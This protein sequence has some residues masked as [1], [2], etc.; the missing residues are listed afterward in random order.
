VLGKSWLSGSS[1]NAFGQTVIN[2]AGPPPTAFANILKYCGAPSVALSNFPST[3]NT[4]GFPSNGTLSAAYNWALSP[5]PSYY[6]RYKIWYTGSVTGGGAGFLMSGFPAI[7]YSGGKGVTGNG[8][9]ATGVKTADLPF[10]GACDT[11][12]TQA[13]PIEMA[14]GFLISSVNS[15]LVGGVVEFTTASTLLFGLGPTTGWKVKPGNLTYNGGAFPA[16]PNIDGSWTITNTAATKFTLDGSGSLNPALISV[17]GAGGPGVQTEMLTNAPQSIQIPAGVTVT[18]L[19]DWGMVKSVDYASTGRQYASSDIVNFLTSTKPRFV[20]VMDFGA[21]QGD[22]STGYGPSGP[23]AYNTQPGHACWYL[24]GYQIKDYLT[25]SSSISNTGSS[26]SYTDVYTC[27]SPP[28]S[29]TVGAYEDGEIVFGQIGSSSANTGVRPG[30]NVNSRGIAPIFDGTAGQILG[31]FWTGSAPSAGTSFTASFSGAGLN[32]THTVNFTSGGTLRDIWVDFATACQADTTLRNLAIFVGNQQGLGNSDGGIFYCPNITFSGG[33]VVASLGGANFSV[34][35]T[36]GAGT[37]SYTF[38][39]LSIGQL[40]NSD[41][42]AFTY[43]KRF[44]G[45]LQ[46]PSAYTIGPAIGAPLEFYADMCT[47][48]NVGLY[49]CIGQLWSDARITATVDMLARAGVREL[50]LE[51]SNETWNPY[52]QEYNFSQAMG[53]TF[54]FTQN[55][56]NSASSSESW[57]GLRH[58]QAAQLAIAAWTAAGKGR[59][60]LFMN[61][62]FQLGSTSDG[63]GMPYKMNGGLLNGT[64]T[65]NTSRVAFSAYG[66]GSLSSYSVNSSAAPN[67][68]VDFS[69]AIGHAP[70]WFGTQFCLGNG[71]AAPVLYTGAPLSSYNALLLAAYNYRYGDASQ[72]SAALDYLYSGGSAGTGELYGNRNDFV[73]ASFT[74][75]VSGTTLTVSGVSGTII[76]RQYVSIPGVPANTYIASGSGS[77]WTLSASGSASGVAGTCIGTAFYEP[78]TGLPL[79]LYTYNSGYAPLGQ[80]TGYYS[81]GVAAASY[82]SGRASLPVGQVG[83]SLLGVINY[84]GGWSF[85]PANSDNLT[86]LKNDLDTLGYTNGYSSSLVGAAS[87]PS[88]GSDTSTLAAQNIWLMLNGNWGLISGVA[89]TSTCFKTDSRSYDLCVRYL[90][91][92][93]IAG[94]NGNP[95]RVS[96]ATWFGYLGN[97]STYPNW[98]S[99]YLGGGIATANESKAVDALRQ[100]AGR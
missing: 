32:G 46:R 51:I 35:L 92:S 83:Q 7:I 33:A 45:W 70:Y 18:D 85:G 53:S 10:G 1:A 90:N 52:L 62:C 40:V 34:A 21:V 76:S 91:E 20:R 75:S 71:I 100:F 30:L 57:V 9:S 41:Y 97:S 59:S 38:G 12:P 63:V 26:G 87:G 47:R 23:L 3:L 5:D 61:L 73:L 14:F 4:N 54:G 67:R 22:R 6:G 8:S 95:N 19:T 72:K 58:L 60:S 39:T 64:N 89:E 48:A 44:G 98:W 49:L 94:K 78:N 50:C 66:S 27:N 77:T 24:G 42:V 2:L 80:P 86:A 28:A 25:S 43:S 74:A 16:G 37:A 31:A 96:L 69:D 68:P 56:D 15:S 79:T 29:P 99:L 82:D 65:T 93:I 11:E 84:E 55:G 17:V 88:G 81:I 36:A 13:S